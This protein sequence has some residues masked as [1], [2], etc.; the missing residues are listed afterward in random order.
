MS[1]GFTG[2][3]IVFWGWQAGLLWLA[4]PM[5]AA[6][7]AH[8]FLTG[9][10]HLAAKD[11]NRFVDVSTLLLAA[12]FVL[13]LSLEP[14]KTLPIVI[15]W[16]PAIFFPLVAAQV[17]SSTGKIPVRSFF[18]TTRKTVPVSGDRAVDISPVFA[19][20]CLAGAGIGQTQDPWY[21]PACFLFTAWALWPVRPKRYPAPVW[22]GVVILAGL[23]GCAGHHGYY[24]ARM[25]FHQL[26]IS[27]Y[28]NSLNPMK[29]TTALGE[30][31]ELKL[32]REIL[33]RV[34]FADRTGGDYL[35]GA[36]YDLFDGSSWYAFHA[37]K[38][39]TPDRQTLTWP[40][41]PP[42]S[43]SETMTFFIRPRRKD[44][45]FLPAG[46]FRIERMDAGSVEINDRSVVRVTDCPSQMRGTAL[47]T[48]GRIFDAPPAP[49]D[50]RIPRREQAAV[51]AAARSLDLYSLDDAA[52]V[53]RLQ[54]FF[55]TGFSY[56]LELTGQG[57]EKTALANFLGPGRKG[58]CELFATATVLLLREAGI[59]A[60]YVTGYVAHE[61][62]GL[63]R[64]IRVRQRDAHAWVKAWID[65]RWV[66]LDTT[67]PGFIQQDRDEARPSPVRDL[68]SFIGFGLS[69]LRHEAFPYVID[70]YGVWLVIPLAL[71]LIFRIGFFKR[72]RRDIRAARKGGTASHSGPKQ[73]VALI[74]ERLAD[75]GFG[76]RNHETWQMWYGRI[77]KGIRVM[78]VSGP[79]QETI[80]L[81]EKRRFSRHGLEPSETAA[82]QALVD[83]ILARLESG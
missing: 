48:P 73:G 34:R 46:T 47:F 54:T 75:G 23:A 74:E 21:F 77:Q 70:R 22:A 40:L 17:Y 1:A 33:F 44:L 28:R 51:A 10:W 53:R 63:D 81:E 18:W 83:R 5:A 64:M 39:V 35:A 26:I 68:L 24:D 38:Q 36:T 56:S 20:A 37:F 25:K 80:R 11:F 67:P 14:E 49:R 12:A 4:V 6:V 76:R 27:Y 7:E 15:R 82:Q 79:L 61:Y 2:A 59:P 42:S 43:P 78:Q 30:I 55:N 19:M 60:R 29:N 58:H 3:V 57:R 31:G 69:R 65:S 41:R 50:T 72:L 32:S 16:T 13:A 8:H 52:V 71:I 45:L 9:R 66:R 62:S